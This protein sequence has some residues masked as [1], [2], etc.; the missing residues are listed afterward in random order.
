M[1]TETLAPEDALEIADMTTNVNEVVARG[2][3][4]WDSIDAELKKQVV[5]REDS[6]DGN[7]GT[8]TIQEN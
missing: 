4:Y 2:K 1:S 6:I 5:T 3:T 8:N 7:K